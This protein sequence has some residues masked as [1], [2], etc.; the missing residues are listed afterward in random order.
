MKALIIEDEFNCSEVLQILLMRNVPAIK[1]IKIADTVDM[2]LR[3][4][5]SFKPDVVFLDIKLG[6][7]TCFDLLEQLDEIDFQII[8]TT[9]YD[10]YAIKAFEYAAVHYL[11]KPV[12]L[13]ELIEAV[14]RCK[15]NLNLIENKTLETV[16]SIYLRTSLRDYK[17]SHD[18]IVYIKADGSYA[19]VY[20]NNDEIFTSKKLVD[21]DRLLPDFFFRIHHSI[22]LNLKWVKELDKPNNLVILTNDVCLPISRRKKAEFKKALTNR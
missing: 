18:D 3:K 22:I 5:L 21:Y 11:L 2:G 4:L 7:Q 19:T 20:T 17:I 1:N 12:I 14:G 16:K 13:S 6:E 10:Q 8:F 15:Q 9:A